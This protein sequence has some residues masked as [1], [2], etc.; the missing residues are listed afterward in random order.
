MELRRDEMDKKSEVEDKKEDNWQK[1]Q[2][3]PN[4]YV[5]NTQNEEE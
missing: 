1:S 4:C 2:P 5:N 3:V